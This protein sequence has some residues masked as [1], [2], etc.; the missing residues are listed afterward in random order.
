MDNIEQEKQ[1]L[2]FQEGVRNIEA[3][4]YRFEVNPNMDGIGFL[5]VLSFGTTKRKFLRGSSRMDVLK[6]ATDI[7]KRSKPEDW[8]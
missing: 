7:V 1:E 3:R 2:E 8:N 6:Q 4:Q 5:G